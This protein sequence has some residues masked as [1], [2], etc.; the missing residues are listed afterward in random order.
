MAWYGDTSCTLL[1]MLAGWGFASLFCL[2]T[3]ILIKTS[4]KRAKISAQ[5]KQWGA[6]VLQRH[7]NG[8]ISLFINFS[9]RF[10]LSFKVSH[11][12]QL[13]GMSAHVWNKIKCYSALEW[14][15]FC[16]LLSLVLSPR[17]YMSGGIFYSTLVMYIHPFSDHGNWCV[18][19]ICCYTL[20]CRK[21]INLCNVVIF[22]GNLQCRFIICW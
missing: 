14:G 15:N 12:L 22:L 19:Q 2:L 5:F 20:W 21:T 6:V 1:F 8:S 17:I 13:S 7:L 11:W 4:T 3:P 16:F 10:F 18:T 9:F